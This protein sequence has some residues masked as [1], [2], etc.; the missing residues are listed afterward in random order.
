VVAGDSHS[1]SLAHV[2]DRLAALDGTGSYLA[3]VHERY[4]LQTRSHE[5]AGSDET[6]DK[7]GVRRVTHIGIEDSPEP[8]SDSLERFLAAG[9]THLAAAG[10]RTVWMGLSKELSSD[11]SL[12]ALTGQ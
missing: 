8:K 5:H 10:I 6:C 1:H 11:S 9:V 4:L 2:A 3:T 7:F 12:G